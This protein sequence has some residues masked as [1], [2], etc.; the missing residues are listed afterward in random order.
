MSTSTAANARKA[1]Q[2]ISL[3]PELVNLY[4]GQYQVKEGPSAGMVIGIE[5]QGAALAL[6]SPTTP[7]GGLRLH[8]ENQERFFITEADLLVEFHRNREGQVESLAIQF[9]GV[10][11]L[12]SKIRLGADPH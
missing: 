2:E 11:T 6:V 7:P 1:R 8:A 4:A 12:A 5:R 3:P 9:A 10:R